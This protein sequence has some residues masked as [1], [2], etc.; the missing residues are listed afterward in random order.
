MFSSFANNIMA[1]FQHQDTEKVAELLD[2]DCFYH[3]Y[4]VR[5]VDFMA[6]T[7]GYGCKPVQNLE[8]HEI[9]LCVPN[10]RAE[11]WNNRIREDFA[12]G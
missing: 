1:D 12:A 7:A 6:E 2:Q 9:L 3:I 11:Y 5:F 4:L 8:M 10:E